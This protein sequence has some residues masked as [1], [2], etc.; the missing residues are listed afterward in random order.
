VTGQADIEEY[1]VEQMNRLLTRL[2]FQVHRAAKTPGPGEIH[3]LRVSMRRFSQGL[4][5]FSGLLPG[6]QVKKVRKTLK[7]M[8]RLT[9]E[10]RNRDIT[11]EFLAAEKL[12]AHRPRLEKERRSYQK[13]FI[14]V[15]RRWSARDFSTKW[16]NG[17]SL[18]SL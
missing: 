3:D 14:E 18:G 7:G 17:L 11:L 16:R 10:I 9:S 8:L 13:Q 15:V 1:A 6:R 5:V 2:A 4:Q 12:A